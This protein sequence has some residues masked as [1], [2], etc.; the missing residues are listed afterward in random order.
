MTA[1]FPGLD[2]RSFDLVA[3][4]RT[5]ERHQSDPSNSCNIMAGSPT[6]LRVLAQGVRSQTN[7]GGRQNGGIQRCVAGNAAPHELQKRA[8]AAQGFPQAVQKKLPSAGGCGGGAATGCGGPCLSE[9]S[10]QTKAMIQPMNVRHS[11]TVPLVFSHPMYSSC[12]P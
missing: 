6:T 1:L 5:A 9:E 3:W 10:A 7:K 2:G 11:F 8:P 12:L 4:G